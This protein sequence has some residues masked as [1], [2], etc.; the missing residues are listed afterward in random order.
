[1]VVLSAVSSVEGVKR[2][3]SRKNDGD[4]SGM[5]LEIPQDNVSQDYAEQQF[6]DPVSFSEDEVG[7]SGSK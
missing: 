5:K 2:P 6:W 3:R 1:M 7:Y 4:S